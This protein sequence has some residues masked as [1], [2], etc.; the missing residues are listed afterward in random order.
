[1]NGIIRL[2]LDGLP[3]KLEEKI[4]RRKGFTL[5][6]LTVVIP[7]I[8]LSTAILVCSPVG[9]REA[10]RGVFCGTNLA[11]IGKAMLLYSQ[12]NGGDY[13]VAGGPQALWSTLGSVNNIGWLKNW[14]EPKT[15]GSAPNNKA[16]ITSCLYLLVRYRMAEPK[17]FVCRGDEATV[18]DLSLFSI[19]PSSIH[20]TW[21]FGDGAQIWPGECVSYS[22]HMPLAIPDPRPGREGQLTTFRIRERGPKESPVCADRNPFLDEHLAGSKPAI[23]DNCYAHGGK[24]QNV[25]YKDMRVDFEDSPLV[26]IGQDNIWVYY[27]GR[28]YQPPQHIGDEG[29]PSDRT[30]A[31]LVNEYQSGTF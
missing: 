5:V 31:Y 14:S 27:D 15:F 17:Q 10:P 12:D 6:D 7:V 19:R 2:A 4:M 23:D 30:D 20:S 9:R 3:R 18:F 24:G 11:G 29:P 13:P 26:G 25:L 28:A 16:T 22:Y 21:D 8:V 1:V